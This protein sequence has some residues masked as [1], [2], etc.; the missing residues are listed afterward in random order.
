MMTE[1]VIPPFKAAAAVLT[2]F[3]PAALQ[4]AGDVEDRDMALADLLLECEPVADFDKSRRWQLE[5]APR[6]EALY[7][8][9]RRP[10]GLRM[11]LAANAEH[12]Q[13]AVQQAMVELIE[14]GNEKIPLEERSLEDLLALARASDWLAG[15]VEKAPSREVLLDQVEKRR[16]LKPFVRLLERGF[17]GRGVELAELHDFLLHYRPSILSLHGPGGIGKSTLLARFVMDVVS[18]T[19]FREVERPF[20]FVYLDVDRTAIDPKDPVSFA[21][22]A[23][24]QL[25]AQNRSVQPLAERVQRSLVAVSGREES[26]Q[27]ESVSPDVSDA[28]VLMLQL[29][30]LLFKQ[31]GLPTLFIV[32]TW[33]EIQ[34]AGTGSEDGVLQFLSQLA[35]S[36]SIRIICAG[37]ARL[38][39]AASPSLENVPG[40]TRFGFIEF[41][42]IAIDSFDEPTAKVYLE[43]IA[44]M[45]KRAIESIIKAVGTAPLSLA[46]AARVIE[47][48]GIGAASDLAMIVAKVKSEQI[49]GQ[50]FTRLLGHIHD[51]ELQRLAQP[52]LVVRRITPDVIQHV[53]ASPCEVIVPDEATADT[54]FMKL[55]DETGLVEIDE[56]DDPIDVAGQKIWPLHYRSDLRQLALL[57]LKR[58]MPDQVEAIHA[59]AI[60]WYSSQQGLRAKAEEI[61]HRLA[62][63][64]LPPVDLWRPDMALWLRASSMPELPAR[65]RA[66][67]LQRL[68]QALDDETRAAADFEIWERDTTEQARAFLGRRNWRQALRL[69]RQR[70][71]RG[72]TSPLWLLEAQA[73]V[74][75]GAFSE[76]EEFLSTAATT[77]TEQG[78]PGQ[79]FTF[80]LLL[81]NVQIRQARFETALETLQRAGQFSSNADEIEE[82]Q[83]LLMQL[84]VWRKLGQ[85]GSAE[86]KRAKTA[87]LERLARPMVRKQLERRPALLRETVAEL[88]AERPDV[89]VQAVR[90]LG[91]GRVRLP[92]S[93]AP[94]KLPAWLVGLL[95]RAA[96]ALERFLLRRPGSLERF[97]RFLLKRPGSSYNLL[98][99]DIL[100]TAIAA[101]ASVGGVSLVLTDF[102]VDLAASL[103]RQKTPSIV[104]WCV[105]VYRTEV[106]AIGVALEASGEP[107]ELESDL[108]SQV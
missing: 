38:R 46:L 52:G 57:D 27:L 5:D 33:E 53:L 77:S 19:R 67:L 29:T 4:P 78:E 98:A 83:R 54:L 88:G 36:Q 2:N 6:R 51:P 108:E 81:A 35:T 39:T 44:H 68:D 89:L 11:A 16:L 92:L 43:G 69:I 31:R 21:K 17:V 10:D 22:E 74:Q 86:E 45:P 23:V 72:P 15:A 87:A 30:E 8:L 84:R 62:R 1:P 97:L 25:A 94:I 66:W 101:G 3:D 91:I 76:A 59:G 56:D 99:I 79:S 75:S 34:A 96:V 7:Q 48:E 103:Q 41:R 102:A 71:G 47:R 58:I 64:D 12:P 90:I 49:Q 32:D 93:W 104:S 61:Y 82:L 100:R 106:D 63:G 73:L 9:G 40:S 37:R 55:V 20:T 85:V 50:L 13:D 107:K 65:G 60:A 80:L 70:S 42:Q 95:A 24:R 26:V 18:P 105:N 28:W 14:G